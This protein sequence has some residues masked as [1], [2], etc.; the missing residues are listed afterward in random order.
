MN[1]KKL[2]V[3]R[4]LYED[5]ALARN[6]LSEYD[7]NNQIIISQIEK[8]RIVLLEDVYRSTVYNHDS[9][10]L[11]VP[12]EASEEVSEEPSES[13]NPAGRKKYVRPDLNVLRSLVG[14]MTDSAVASKLGCSVQTVY[15]YRRQWGVDPITSNTRKPN[16]RKSWSSAE[17][18]LLGTDTD[19]NVAKALRR[20]TASVRQRRMRL[21]IPLYKNSVKVL[22]EHSHLHSSF[23]NEE[24][25]DLLGIPKRI[26]DSVLDNRKTIDDIL[27]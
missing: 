2:E 8:L 10:A 19:T 4:K 5:I 1:E 25:A 14:T 11:P 3:I 12:D 21:D 9:I 15:K 23:S 20:T 26:V 16:D 27:K 7:H 24:L 18:V 17:E 22:H 13:P 6:Q